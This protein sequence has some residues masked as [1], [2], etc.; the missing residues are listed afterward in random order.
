MKY[1]LINVKFDNFEDKSKE[2]REELL[3]YAKEVDKEI[4]IYNKGAGI[5][6]YEK[7]YYFNKYSAIHNILEN[8]K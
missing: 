7:D 4:E 6:G 5:K 3:E 1:D 2:Q 8:T